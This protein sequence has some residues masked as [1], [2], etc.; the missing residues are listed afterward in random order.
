MY[1]A[2]AAVVVN[3]I[4]KFFLVPAGAV[5]LVASYVIVFI[6]VFSPVSNPPLP[7]NASVYAANLLNTAL[8]SDL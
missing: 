7:W 5:L 8:E 6:Q 1:A 4:D 2:L 3:E